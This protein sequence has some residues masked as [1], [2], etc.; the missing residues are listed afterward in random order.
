MSVGDVMG[1]AYF[2]L[3]HIMNDGVR[4]R[5]ARPFE[6]WTRAA[7]CGKGPAEAGPPGGG[8]GQRPGESDEGPRG[9]PYLD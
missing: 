5:E 1:N 3:P 9:L 4:A 6:F 2:A 8:A 7:A